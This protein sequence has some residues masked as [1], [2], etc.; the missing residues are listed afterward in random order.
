M[1]P[2]VRRPARPP[3]RPADGPGFPADGARGRSAR[4]VPGPRPRS[5]VIRGGD[6]ARRRDAVFPVP[7]GVPQ[8]RSTLAPS[9]PSFSMKFS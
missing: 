9:T 3:G 7:R 4:N 8:G 5:G 2:T 1:S 6:G